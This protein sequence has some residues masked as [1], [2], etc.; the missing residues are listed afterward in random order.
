MQGHYEALREE[1]ERVLQSARETLAQL[2]TG[3][4]LEVLVAQARARKPYQ[5]YNTL[6]ALMQ[7]LEKIGQD[8]GPTCQA[9]VMQGLL[10]RLTLA[11]RED[12]LGFTLTPE[13]RERYENSL[14][15]ILN[16]PAEDRRLDDLFLKDLALATGSLFPAG[17]RVVEPCS[18]LQRSLLFRSGPSQ[19]LRFLSCLLRAGGSRPFFRLHIHLSEAS[20]L[21]EASWRQTCKCLAEMLQVNP[22]VKGVIG[23]AWLYDPALPMVSPRLGFINDVLRSAG[24]QWFYSHAEGGDSGA[25]ATSRTRRDA[26]RS[27]G[28][29]PRC[30]VIC[31]GRVAAIAWRAGEV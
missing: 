25:F 21:D 28:Y 7:S 11:F 5:S 16:T 31:W 3:S 30:Y 19:A 27:A 10:A 9:R 4:D 23:A 22:W 1:A 15:R 24:A 29:K 18:V 2:S 12:G 8:L 26:A 6:P 20:H 13:V 17:D 14:R